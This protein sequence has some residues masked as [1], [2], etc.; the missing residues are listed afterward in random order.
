MLFDEQLLRLDEV[1]HEVRDPHLSFRVQL[2][3]VPDLLVGFFIEGEGV[4]LAD[5]DVELIV[6]EVVLFCEI[7]GLEGTF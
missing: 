4:E 1:I 5:D 7:L 6:V 3:L 2:A